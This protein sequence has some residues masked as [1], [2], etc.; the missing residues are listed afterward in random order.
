MIANLARLV[1]SGKGSACGQAAVRARGLTRSAFITLP[2]MDKI[3]A[4]R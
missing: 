4:E 2:V 3:M 1:V